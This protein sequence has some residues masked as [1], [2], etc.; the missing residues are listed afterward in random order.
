MSVLPPSIYLSIYVIAVDLL[1]SRQV[2]ELTNDACGNIFES[3]CF[4]FLFGYK[5]YFTYP[6]LNSIP[7]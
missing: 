6:N 7:V 2:T 5:E 3:M 1:L 4:P